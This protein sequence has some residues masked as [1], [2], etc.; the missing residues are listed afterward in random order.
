MR[1]RQRTT[2]ASV[3]KFERLKLCAARCKFANRNLG[4]KQGWRREDKGEVDFRRMR[5]DWKRRQRQ[6][7]ILF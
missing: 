6:S 2:R 3:M 5:I 1:S 7:G 4:G